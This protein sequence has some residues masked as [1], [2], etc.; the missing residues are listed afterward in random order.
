MQIAIKKLFLTSSN[1][2]GIKKPLSALSL[3]RTYCIIHNPLMY[4]SFVASLKDDLVERDFNDCWGQIVQ[5][6]LYA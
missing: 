3:L 5:G 1:T 2:V 6:E 4:N